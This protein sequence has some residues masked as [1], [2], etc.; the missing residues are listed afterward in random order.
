[1]EDHLEGNARE[2]IQEEQGNLDIEKDINT[3]KEVNKERAL[4]K[5]DFYTEA[6]QSDDLKIPIS[7]LLYGI[8]FAPSKTFSYFRYYKPWGWAFIFLLIVD[9]I[10]ML[11]SVLSTNWGNFLLNLPPQISSFLNP[12]RASLGIFSGIFIFPVSVLF[13]MLQ[14][15]ILHLLTEMFRGRG[16]ILS[17]F[18]ALAFTQILAIISALFKFFT[19]LA[20]KAGIFLFF[21]FGMVFLIWQV[22]LTI[23]ALKEIYLISTGRAVLI[24]FLP[25][26]ILIAVII[27]MVISV[28]AFL[29]PLL[30][31]LNNL[32]LY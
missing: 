22:V 17:L 27:F 9:V 20:G 30:G 1:M 8:I 11:L 14:V 21:P 2:Q 29:A 23:I 24:F 26:I 5:A 15:G 7:E 18:S 31:S 6:N 32:N 25:F 16:E 13:F 10:S 19:A 12:M 4:G 3:E 28:V